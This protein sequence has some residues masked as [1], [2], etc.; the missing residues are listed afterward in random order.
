MGRFKIN[1]YLYR[2]IRIIL[3]VIIVIILYIV[4]KNLI[5]KTLNYKNYLVLND[6]FS[7]EE[8]KSIQDCIGNKSDI[9]S[10]FDEC[11][12]NI[13]SKIKKKL[14]VNYMNV[15][16]ARL[17]NN[18]NNDAQ[19][20]HRDVKPKWNYNGTYPNV[21][22][23]VCYFDDASLSIGN[24][25]I[26]SKPG[27][28]IIFNSTNLHKAN[29]IDI[30][31]NKQRRVLQYFHVFFDKDEEEMFYKNHSFCEHIDGTKEMKYL[32]YLF[33]V[34][35]IFEYLN[36]GRFINNSGCDKMFMTNI[37]KDSYVTTIDGIKY[38]NYF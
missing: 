25:I 31:K 32:T 26:I 6:I 24:N 2:L 36:I 3:I 37:K 21:Y 4:V 22:T 35:F 5:L 13:L 7:Q 29:N 19:S 23:I 9:K 38:Y 1:N 17:S 18:N 27:D 14:N 8:I 28:I 16:L 12:S 15:G 30:F 20:Y 33:D 34:K 11:Q 10:C